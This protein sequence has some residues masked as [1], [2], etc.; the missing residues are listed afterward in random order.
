MH[1]RLIYAEVT[2]QHDNQLIQGKVKERSLAPGS[3]I[4]RYYNNNLVLNTLAYDVEFPDRE[5]REYIANII[6]ENMLTR[7]DSDG[8]I[9]IVL[10]CVFDFEK[11]N[12]TYEIKDRYLY[13]KNSRRRLQKSIQ[14]QKLKVLQKDRTTNFISLKDIKESTLIEVAEF[15]KARNIYYELAFMYSVSVR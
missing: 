12:T 9:T 15:A 13:E 11:D 7:V 6:V 14:G 4:I 5:V 10:D 3:S 2:L 8:Y 1:N